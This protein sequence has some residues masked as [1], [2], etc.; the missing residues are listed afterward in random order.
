MPFRLH[1]NCGTGCKARGFDKKK[2]L[3]VCLWKDTPEDK[4]I[5]L[6]PEDITKFILT[7]PIP[8]C[9]CNHF[10]GLHIYNGGSIIIGTKEQIDYMALCGQKIYHRVRKMGNKSRDI[11]YPVPLKLKHESNEALNDYIKSINNIIVCPYHRCLVS[12]CPRHKCKIQKNFG[13]DKVISEVSKKLDFDAYALA[14]V[15]HPFDG[16]Q[17]RKIS[18][19]TGKADFIIEHDDWYPESPYQ[20]AIRETWEEAGIELSPRVSN[21][22]RNKA[23]SYGLDI[24]IENVAHLFYFVIP[25]DFKFYFYN[26]YLDNPLHARSIL[27]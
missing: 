21:I 17:F 27:R 26:L 19:M 16:R 13:I 5:L 20:C 25:H 8:V 22:F 10:R 15:E 18:F 4:D 9:P 11:C 23:L 7:S 3:A 12:K 6:E 2:A 24:Y 1:H 14:V